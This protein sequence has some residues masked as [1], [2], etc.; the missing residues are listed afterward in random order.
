VK[1]SSSI[2]RTCP[3]RSPGFIASCSREAFSRLR[4]HICPRPTPTEIPLIVGISRSSPSTILIEAIRSYYGECDFQGQQALL[5]PVL[6]HGQPVSG[7]L[8]STL[9]LDV[10]SLVLVF[11][12]CPQGILDFRPGRLEMKIT[13]LIVVGELLGTAAPRDGGVELALPWVPRLR[14]A[15]LPGCLAGRPFAFVVGLQAAQ[16]LADHLVSDTRTRQTKPAHRAGLSEWRRRGSNPRP[17][18]CDSTGAGL[19][20]IARVQK[21]HYEWILQIAQVRQIRRCSWVWA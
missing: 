18:E 3:R 10:S 12:D 9:G 21:W 6:S 17:L 7:G 19:A 11:W 4:R 15:A 14:E 2:Y 5:W 13:L 16:D 8:R 1:T 20:G